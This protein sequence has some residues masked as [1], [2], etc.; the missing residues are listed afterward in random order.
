M[1]RPT[2]LYN[3]SFAASLY[4]AGSTNAVEYILNPKTS[5]KI[6]HS[7]DSTVSI[8]FFRPWIHTV[9]TMEGLSQ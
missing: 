1:S 4:N 6:C 3:T 9:S 7:P 8:H 2:G 5:M